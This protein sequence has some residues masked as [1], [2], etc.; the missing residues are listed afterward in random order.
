MVSLS[1]LS[2][3]SRSSRQCQDSFLLRGMNA[4]AHVLSPLHL[5][6]APSSDPNP[7]Q[8]Q[9][10]SGRADETAHSVVIVGG[11]V[12]RLQQLAHLSDLGEGGA[13]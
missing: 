10:A 3:P 8:R 13:L 1:T 5:P 6:P 4:A 7:H 9:V 2:P 12:C 11:R